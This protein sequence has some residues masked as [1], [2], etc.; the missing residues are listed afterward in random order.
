MSGPGRERTRV[1]SLSSFTP[2]AHPD[3]MILATSGRGCMGICPLPGW[4]P[5][6]ESPSQVPV[7]EATSL[8]LLPGQR[9]GRGERTPSLLVLLSHLD[10]VPPS[11]NVSSAEGPEGPECQG[12]VRGPFSER[13]GPAERAT[14][15]A[16]AERDE[17]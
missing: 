11:S 6:P 5:L 7:P 10:S 9:Q 3:G 16:A 15:M 13:P 1:L 4:L 12:P 17:P 8:N 14:A 2:A